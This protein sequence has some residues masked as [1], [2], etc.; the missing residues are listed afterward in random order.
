MVAFFSFFLSSK[1]GPT[2]DS[3]QDKAQFHWAVLMPDR[4]LKVMV[5]VFIKGLLFLG[6]GDSFKIE[7]SG[8]RISKLFSHVRLVVIIAAPPP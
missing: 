5:L 3:K 4:D 6:A 1:T 7:K 8:G 2:S